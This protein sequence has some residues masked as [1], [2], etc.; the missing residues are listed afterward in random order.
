MIRFRQIIAP[1]LVGMMTL[2]SSI[3]GHSAQTITL[4][5]SSAFSGD[6]ASMGE[7]FLA[8]AQAGFVRF[9]DRTG[10]TIQLTTLDD[11]YDPRQTAPNTRRLI[12]EEKVIA[13]FG[14]IGTPTVAVSA[15]ISTET[16]T[17][18]FAPV[19]GSA[20]IRPKTPDRYIINYRASYEEEITAAFDALM[21]EH[22]LK[23]SDIA[24]F[25]QQDMF[26]SAG[27][28]YLNKLMQ[29]H[30]IQRQT[31]LFQMEYSRNTLAVEHAVA[32]LLIRHPT[33]K[34]IFIVGSAAPSA[35]FIRLTRQY[36]LNPLFIGISF[37]GSRLFLEELQD[38]PANIIIS[39]VVPHFEEK[40]LPIIVDFHQ[41]MTR[42][43]PQ[44]KLN[45]LSLE[46]Y[47]AARI[48]TK[49]LPK[50]VQMNRETIIDALESL[51][52]FDIGLGVPLTLSLEE[53]QASHSIWLTHL[54][55]GKLIPIP[56]TTVPK[57]YLSNMMST[58]TTG[59]AQ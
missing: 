11:A 26:G 33:P 52:Q 30:G 32:D 37:M 21:Q 25:N 40:S 1:F 15:P 5:M 38:V 7:D 18:L 51:G 3:H 27:K 54:K 9:H 22:S 35:K 14:N 41:D 34:V 42:F 59:K 31:G 47:I 45:P 6:N 53:H 17:L 56:F 49:A 46:G 55:D 16:K 44:S 13:L 4:G 28:T 39:Q 20:L 19:T 43:S 2:Y 36:G 57:L 23:E 12:T 29:K 58:E 50:T 24:L 10:H 48:F 8:G